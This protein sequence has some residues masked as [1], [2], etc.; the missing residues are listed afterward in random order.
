M[1][2]T[3]NTKKIIE[4]LLKNI[5][6][7]G[8]NVNQLARG[9]GI[10]VG[11]SHKIL[12]EFKKE[13]FVRVTDLKNSIYYQLN[14]NNKDVVDVCKLI[15]REKKKNLPSKT[16]IYSEEIEKFEKAEIIILFGSILHKKDFNDVDVLFITDKV[17]DVNRF[18]N[19]ISK[20][21][22]KPI[23]PLIM[24][25]DDFIKNIKNNNV[26]LEIINKGIIISGEEKY[27]EALK[28]AG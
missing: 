20:I 2:I 5:N 1:N 15:L 16:K 14:L 24:K 11:S 9:T 28:N 13:N 4:F 21:R 25:F 27:M 19:E 10:S 23:N 6:E 8:F 12:Q 7:I 26:I 17:K 3:K 18:C 22:T